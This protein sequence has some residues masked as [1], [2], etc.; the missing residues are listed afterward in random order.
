M[1]LI[2]KKLLFNIKPIILHPSSPSPLFKISIV[3]SIILVLTS[4]IFV[5][6]FMAVVGSMLN[7]NTKFKRIQGGFIT[8]CIS[9]LGIWIILVMISFKTTVNI[10]NAFYKFISQTSYDFLFVDILKCVLKLYSIIEI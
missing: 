3:Q 7:S 9:G 4:S 2:N 10:R 6:L 1:Y 5:K 8:F